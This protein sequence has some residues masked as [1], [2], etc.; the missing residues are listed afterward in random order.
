MSFIE[1]RKLYGKIKRKRYYTMGVDDNS[2]IY[3]IGSYILMGTYIYQEIEHMSRLPT[4][5]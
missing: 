1:I 3:F 5:T 4:F 2:M